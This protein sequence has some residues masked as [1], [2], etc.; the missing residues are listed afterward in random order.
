MVKKSS[1]KKTKVPNRNVG[2]FTNITGYPLNKP[3]NCPAELLRKAALGGK[4]SGA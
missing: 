1:S 3:S 2:P 4:R